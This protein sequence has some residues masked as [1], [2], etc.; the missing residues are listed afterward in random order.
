MCKDVSKK[1]VKALLTTFRN[2]LKTQKQSFGIHM[3]F[4]LY[5][6]QICTYRQVRNGFFYFYCKKKVLSDGVSTEPIDIELCPDHFLIK[7]I[8][9]WT[10]KRE[11][12]GRDFLCSISIW[13][14][15]IFINQVCLKLS[16]SDRFKLILRN[17][18]KFHN[19]FS[20]GDKIILNSKS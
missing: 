12:G 3:G 14:I 17:Y 9:H 1:R 20:L 16:Y 6:N 11:G 7:K 19:I 8:L 15:S 2:V 10:K 4:K 18:S 5:N 13:I